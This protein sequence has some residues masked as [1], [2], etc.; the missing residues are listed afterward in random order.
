MLWNRFLD[1]LVQ[2]KALTGRELPGP[3]PPVAPTPD[4]SAKE[5]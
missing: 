2:A 3:I 5:V 1:H 4:S